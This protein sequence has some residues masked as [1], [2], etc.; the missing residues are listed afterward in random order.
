MSVLRQPL[1]PTGLLLIVLG[2]GNWF[3][4]LDK[5]REYEALLAAGK[6]A[7]PVEHFEDFQELNAHTTATLLSNLQRGSD[8]HSIV[9]SKLDFYKV[10]RSGGRILILLGLFCIVAS[11]VRSWYRQHREERQLPLRQG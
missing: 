8:E 11:V 3:T 2:F 10:A 5:G 6:I 7:P 1:L 4:G 9:N